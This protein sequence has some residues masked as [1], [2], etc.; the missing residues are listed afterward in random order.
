MSIYE[1]EVIVRLIESTVSYIAITICF[2]F[3]VNSCEKE[4][5]EEI[6]SKGVANCEQVNREN[7]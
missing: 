5:I 4:K 1:R 2:C 7:K 3:L 6:K